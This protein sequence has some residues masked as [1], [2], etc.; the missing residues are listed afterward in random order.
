[1]QLRKGKLS[2]PA[3]L[4]QKDSPALGL[5]CSIKHLLC[6]REVRSSAPFLHCL[7]LEV[8]GVQELRTETVPECS[9]N[10]WQ[11]SET[12]GECRNKAFI[13]EGSAYRAVGWGPPEAPKP[14]RRKQ[15]I[16][17]RPPCVLEA[18]LSC[19]QPATLQALFGSVRHSLGCIFKSRHRRTRTIS[20]S[21]QTSPGHGWVPEH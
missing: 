16:V 1:M 14:Q 6:A 21:A 8:E 4:G 20:G 17:S 11:H 15:T 9:L 10:P 19:H 3:F 12:E 7:S 13:R 2:L 18:S 5:S